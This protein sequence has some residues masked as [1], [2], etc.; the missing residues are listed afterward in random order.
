MPDPTQ[1]A[2]VVTATLGHRMLV[3]RFSV[4]VQRAERAIVQTNSPWSREEASKIANGDEAL[5]LAQRERVQGHL[6]AGF[7]KHDLHAFRYAHSHITDD[8]FEALAT[9]DTETSL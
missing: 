9:E 6:A 4:L 5:G 7:S 1:A 8:G 3:R 2:Q